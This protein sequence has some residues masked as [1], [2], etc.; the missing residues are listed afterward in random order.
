[1]FEY[2]HGTIRASGPTHITLDVNGVGYW[3]L[4]PLGSR[5]PEAG[6]E[7]T[8]WVHFAVREDAQTLYGFDRR[9]HRDLFRE[10][11]KVKGV[12]PSMGLAL[13]SGLAPAELVAAIASADL[14]SMTSI[15]GVGKKTAEQILLD[16]RDRAPA[17]ACS[18]GVETKDRS[19]LT[20][21]APTQTAVRTEAISALVHMGFKPKQA[22][23]N[24]TKAAQD[25]PAADVEALVRAAFQK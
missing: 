3:L 5:F 4:T 7:A 20:P 10:L 12:G 2:L 11:L 13:L 23:D 18:L 9:E 21:A 25:N 8:A 1:M 16:L 14:A 6:A 22:E 17:L 19:V 24:V 15:K